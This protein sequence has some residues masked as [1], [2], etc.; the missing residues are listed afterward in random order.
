MLPINSQ[1]DLKGETMTKDDLI[2][3]AL[4]TEAT[5]S[6]ISDALE[7]WGFASDYD[8]ICLFI[9]EMNK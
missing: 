8:A 6:D 2:D 3:W 5:F 1:N 7:Y 9:E 4:E